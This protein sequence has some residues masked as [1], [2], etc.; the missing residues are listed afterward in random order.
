MKSTVKGG[1]KEDI[2]NIV[3]DKKIDTLR[4]EIW[5]TIFKERGD[6]S[7]CDVVMALGIV[8]YELI[9]HSDEK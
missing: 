9:H 8:Q 3:M 4:K 7:D 5:I 1:I 6:L 2:Y